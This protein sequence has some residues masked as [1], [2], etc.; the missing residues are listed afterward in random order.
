MALSANK[1][2]AGDTGRINQINDIIDDLEDLEDRKVEGIPGQI[3]AYGG[4]AAPT[5]WFLC[6]GSAVSRV[7]YADLFTA[8][9]TKYGVGD[10]STTF[11]VPN[12]K[13]RVPV[14]L[15]STITDFN[16]RGKTGGS[17]THTLTTAEMPAHTHGAPR[18]VGGSGDSGFYLSGGMRLSSTTDSTGGGGAHENMPPYLIVNY[19]I[20][21]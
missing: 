3:T 12:L 17:K 11:N 1:I 20:R 7:T 19:I 6:D 5:G 2:T 18:W 15:D 14:G 10:G 8:I 13:G 9:G 4:D 16:D 21:Y